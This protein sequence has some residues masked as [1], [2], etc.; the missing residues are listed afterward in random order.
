MTVR[1]VLVGV[2]LTYAVSFVHELP[3]ETWAQCGLALAMMAASGFAIGHAIGRHHI[4][5]IEDLP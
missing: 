3:R 2:A 4:E 1:L 5:R